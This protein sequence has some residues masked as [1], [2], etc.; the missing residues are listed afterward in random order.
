MVE[1]ADH[2]KKDLLMAVVAGQA[3]NNL[4]IKKVEDHLIRNLS[5]E[6]V[7]GN[8]IKESVDGGGNRPLETDLSMV[9]TAG[10]LKHLL[11]V[12]KPATSK[13]TCRW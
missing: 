7:A 8:V 12:L 11:G 3:Q 9:E 5:M 6:E 1:A 2:L 13:R 10:H 4:S